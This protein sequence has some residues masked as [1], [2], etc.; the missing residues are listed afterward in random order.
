[1]TY[2]HDTTK[3]KNIIQNN[4]EK[5]KDT[6]IT[7]EKT[8]TTNKCTTGKTKRKNPFRRN[9]SP[10]SVLAGNLTSTD[11]IRMLVSLYYLYIIFKRRLKDVNVFISSLKKKNL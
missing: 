6:G 1:M 4:S 7:S 10:V 3:A 8:P 5:T 9:I 11:D 2:I